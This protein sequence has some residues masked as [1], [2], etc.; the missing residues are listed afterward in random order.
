MASLIKWKKGDYVRLGRAVADFNRKVEASEIEDKD[1]LPLM[2]NYN[3]LKEEI[4]SRAEL[5]RVIKSLKR[6]T[7]DNLTETYEYPSGEVVTEWERKEITYAKRRALIN[8]ERERQT[9][10]Q[11]NESIGMGYERLSEIDAIE[12][13]FSNIGTKVGKDFERALKRLFKVGSPDT[14]LTKAMQF[15]ENFMQS[16]ASLSNYDHYDL[17]VKR[18]NKI[19]N[20]EKF[21]EYV[22]QSPILMDIFLYYKDK[23]TSIYSTFRTNEEAF[24][25]TLAY[26]LGINLNE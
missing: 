13:S 20:P 9:I 16:L 10:L 25:Y 21:F 26:H 5:N 24:D 8:L 6:A 18:L 23:D 19:K 7:K 3:T 12:R 11:E 14:K 4:L 15:R 1:I 2:K 22:K 17:L